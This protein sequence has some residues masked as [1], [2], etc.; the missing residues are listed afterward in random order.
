MTITVLGAT[1]KTGSSVVSTLLG[2]GVS[3]RV[4]ARSREKLADLVAKGATAAPAEITD[5][6]ALTKVIAGSDAVY[7]M[8]PGDYTQPDL[9]GQYARGAEAIAAAIKAAGVR[10]V[11][12]LS[13]VGGELPSGN[14]PIAGLHQAEQR[15]RAIPGLDLLLLRAGYFYENHYGT[16]QLI[17]QQGINGGALAPDAPIT[18]IEARDIGV[19]AAQAL[20]KGDFSGVTVRELGGPRPLTMTE[21]TRILGRAVGKPDLPY[22]QFPAEGFIDGL[23]KNGFSADAA[24]LLAEMSDGLNRGVI[25]SQ[26]GNQLVKTPTTFEAFADEF[27]R[28]YQAA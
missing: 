1:G 22:V 19:V 14:G 3:V 18:M 4:V 16:L 7:A 24:R 11:A 28:A 21:T 17:K 13:S 6:D 23:Q 8:I 27:A 26:P 15:L 5:S 2:A 25:K 10:R 12:F 20:L 9:L